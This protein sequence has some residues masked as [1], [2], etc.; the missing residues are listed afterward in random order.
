MNDMSK[1]ILRCSP[2]FSQ[3]SILI[4]SLS[5]VPAVQAGSDTVVVVLRFRE[6]VPYSIFTVINIITREVSI[7]SNDLL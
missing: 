3:N 4:V 7:F 1:I 6:E 5:L 2:F